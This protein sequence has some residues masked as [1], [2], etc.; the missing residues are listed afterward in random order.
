MQP[1]LSISAPAA[2]MVY[3]NGRF[4]GEA[5]AEAPLV[6]PVCAWGALYLEF[7]PL[8][9]G[10]ASF[11]RRLTLSDGRVLAQGLARDIYAVEWPGGVTEAE[12]VPPRNVFPAHRQVRFDQGVSFALIEDEQPRLEVFGLQIP[13]P[14]GAQLPE[15]IRRDEQFFFVGDA[16]SGRYLAAVSGSGPRLLGVITGA[17]IEVEGGLVRV[18]VPQG[19]LVGHAQLETWRATENAL[20]R[21]EC[22]SIWE[23]G[24]PRWPQTAE[25]SAIAALEAAFA[26]RD[27]ETEGYLAPQFGGI[28][29]LRDCIRDFSGCTA[30]KYPLADGRAAVGL[31]HSLAPNFAHVVPLYYRAAMT[32][33]AQGPW[34]IE[35]LEF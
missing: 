5:S 35:S 7:R 27:S 28:L 32:G 9:T 25:E 3:I 18:I 31:L 30:L 17:K 23:S 12:L 4:A 10:W 15:L 13:L 26:G 11:A 20:V 33:G 19:D 1:I 24:A 34:Q 29:R 16:D 14:E 6:M 8:E 22:E 2:G 21:E